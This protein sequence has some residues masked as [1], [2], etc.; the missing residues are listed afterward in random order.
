MTQNA[1]RPGGTGILY[2]LGAVQ[3]LQVR[4]LFFDCYRKNK[5]LFTGLCVMVFGHMSRVGKSS[6]V[7]PY[8]F[9]RFRFR[10]R[11]LKS[12]DSGSGSSSNF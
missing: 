12:Y 1:S 5:M 10:F 11:L 8:L 4:R 7:E 9:L 3:A 2:F 6:V